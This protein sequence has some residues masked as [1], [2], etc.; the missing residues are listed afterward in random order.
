MRFFNSSFA[1]KLNFSGDMRYS[2]EI[3]TSFRIASF[4]SSLR[5]SEDTPSNFNLSWMNLAASCSLVILEWVNFKII[6]ICV[7]I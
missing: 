4:K 3:E 7:N 5:L 1:A 2:Y 6:R